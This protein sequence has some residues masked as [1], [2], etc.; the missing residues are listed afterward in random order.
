[1]IKFVKN[2]TVL[3]AVTFF[4][5]GIQAQKKDLTDDH[6]FKNNFK[7]ITS[8]LPSVVKW[9]DDGHLILRKDGKGPS[10]LYCDNISLAELI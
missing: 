10:P 9:L 4:S 8:P 2:T 7:G 1:M 5:L 6:Y 3:L